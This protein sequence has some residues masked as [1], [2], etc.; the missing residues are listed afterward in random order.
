MKYIIANWKMNPASAK[1]AKQLAKE[2]DV[3]DLII[4]PPFPYLE[5]VGGVLKKAKLGAQDLFWEEKG[6]FT[7]EVSGS[8]EKELGAEYVIIGHSER[9]LNAGETDDMVA[10]KIAAAMQDGLTPILCVGETRAEKDKNKTKEVVE[11]E[12]RIGLSRVLHEKKEIIV[13]YEPI[14]AIGTGNPDTPQSMVDMVKYMRELLK[15]IGS[16]LTV[17]I[18]Y[19][20]SV[21]AENVEKFMEQKE[22]D[23]ALVGGASLKSEEIKTIVTI[24]KKYAK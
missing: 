24:A 22:I 20:G 18:V 12:L 7:G 4:C 5:D 19:G 1:E 9:R 3:A 10:K 15:R 8:Q 2:S 11:R 13:A 6:A 16:Q 17:R 21:K 23:G 14:W